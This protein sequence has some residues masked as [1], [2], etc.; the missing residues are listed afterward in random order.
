MASIQAWMH[1]K[2]SEET[3]MMC[4][5][6]VLIDPP[7]PSTDEVDEYL[8]HVEGCVDISRGA[9]FPVIRPSEALREDVKPGT[10]AP[11]HSAS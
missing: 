1:S 7:W 6:A 5:Q 9:R 10:A 11:N 2:L 8:R 3:S 4:E